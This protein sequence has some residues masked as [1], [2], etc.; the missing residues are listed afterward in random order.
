MSITPKLGSLAV[1]ID[2]VSP[3]PGNP[4]Q[5][6]VGAI[7]ESLLQF[8]QVKP[9][10]VQ[11]GSGHIVAGNH[12]WRA[13]KALGW[14]DVAAVFVPMD[15]KE[16][17]RFV[18]ADNRTQELGSYDNDALGAMLVELDREGLLAGT[19]YDSDDVDALLRSIDY[20]DATGQG[21]AGRGRAKVNVCA[22]CGAEA[23][24]RFQLKL[25][26]QEDG[27]D[28]SR[29][30]GSLSL[31]ETDWLAHAQPNMNRPVDSI[32]ALKGAGDVD[33]ENEA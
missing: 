21:G 7:S 6:D 4:R 24:T 29:G 19:G 32:E 14:K 8:G 11:A 27:E 1:P 31:C 17:R 33:D 3:Y 15:D 20:S 30:A 22:F 23:S 25:Q 12:L 26:W 9:I 16:A 18:I 28:K 5:G 13:A 2:S 10:V